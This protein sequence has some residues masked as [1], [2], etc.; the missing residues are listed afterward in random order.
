MSD[1]YFF[2]KSKLINK[3]VLY[4]GISLFGA[5]TLYSQELYI[6]T[7]EGIKSAEECYC[8]Y[9]AMS[10]QSYGKEIYPISV[11]GN[12]Y[13][14]DKKPTFFSI[15]AVRPDSY[16]CSGF[17][18]DGL[19][20]NYSESYSGDCTGS[21]LMSNQ[22]LTLPTATTNSFCDKITLIAN[23]CTG[24]QRF[25]WEYSTDG[26]NYKETKVS[27]GVNENYVFVKSKYLPDNYSGN[28]YFRTLIDSDPYTTAENIYSNTANYKITSCSPLLD[29]SPIAAKVKCNNESNGSVT[30][31][32][33]TDI[34]DSQKLLLNLYQ[35]SDFKYHK[36]VSSTDIVNKTFTWDKLAQGTYTIKYQAQ[37]NSENNT[38]VGALPVI[39]PSFTIENV[40]SLTFK[41]TAIQPACSTDKGA[42]LITASGGTP[43]YYYMLDNETLDNKHPF[44]S[45]HTILNLS[46]GDH[47]VIVV[48]SNNCIEK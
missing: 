40:E 12:I 33:L 7:Y 23:G 36:F 47:K 1:F 16:M 21:G 34:T 20:I 39:S 6:F 46:D 10:I 8:N 15:Q 26:I 37:N 25:F 13:I 42:I 45:P 31:K 41:S 32:F 9:F 38:T 22:V 2:L 5:N 19:D 17:C 44:T 3:Y 27:T 48:D 11:N 28:I 4:I 30:L 14:F 43:P 18:G 35:G 29:G 24:T